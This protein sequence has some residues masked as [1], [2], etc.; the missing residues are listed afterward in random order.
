[1]PYHEAK[2]TQKFP[3]RLPDDGLFLFWGPFGCGVKAMTAFIGAVRRKCAV[4]VLAADNY[5]A[6]TD[7]G[8]GIHRR[9]GGFN[10][11]FGHRN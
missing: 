6:L 4:E 11:V 8:D 10:V 3:V 9:S 7:V 5:I 2:P 1:M